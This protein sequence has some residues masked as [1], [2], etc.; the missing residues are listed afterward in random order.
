M[1]SS[2]TA[3]GTHTDDTVVF[4]SFNHLSKLQPEVI[5]TWSGILAGLP[6]SR[7]LV[8]DRYLEDRDVRRSLLAQFAAHGIASEPLV[9]RGRAPYAQYLATYAE[10][11]VA[12]DTFPRT[13]GTTTAEALWMG[14][15]VITLAGPRYVERISASKLTALGLETLVTQDGD[16][17]IGKAM[18]LARATASRARLRAELRDRMARSPLCDGAGLA[19]EMENAFQAMWQAWSIRKD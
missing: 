1:H 12:L 3:R 2:S 5:V 6:R 11:D 7:L 10:I 15:P 19:R 16:A 14:V 8:M 17:Y 13:G 18:E 9:L 4:G